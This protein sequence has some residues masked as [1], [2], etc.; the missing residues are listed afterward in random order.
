MPAERLF[1]VRI[2]QSGLTFNHIA[3]PSGG[4]LY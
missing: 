2:D 4:T 3:R 1:I